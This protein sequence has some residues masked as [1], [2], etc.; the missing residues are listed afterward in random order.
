MT[1]DDE[2]TEMKVQVPETLRTRL[3]GVTVITDSTLSETV[4]EAVEV[5]LQALEEG[6]VEA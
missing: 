4:T 3:D 2:T 6:R 1:E 5:Y